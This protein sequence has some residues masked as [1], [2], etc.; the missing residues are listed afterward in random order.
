MNINYENIAQQ[1]FDNLYHDISN[2]SNINDISFNYQN[3]RRQ[4]VDISSIIPTRPTARLITSRLIPSRLIP[5]R[6]ISSRL[7]PYSLI[8]IDIYYTNR[9]TDA[10]YDSIFVTTELS[11]NII[12]NDLSNDNYSNRTSLRELVRNL[13]SE[14]DNSFL[15]NFINSTFE[16]DKQKFKK[17][18]SNDELEKL[19]PQKFNKKNE[20]NT[21]IQCPIYCYDFEENE[22]IIKLPC[23]HNYNCEGITKWLTEESNT[24]PV[25]RYEFDYKE[26]NI[27]NKRRTINNDDI[28]SNSEYNDVDYNYEYTSDNSEENNENNENNED[29]ISDYLIS[30]EEELL[31]EILL[32]SYSNNTTN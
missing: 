4:I 24:C 23:N 32:Y 16:N 9:R 14:E 2:I 30:E 28:E 5:S 29:N 21:N 31:Q 6:L 20:S 11:N 12:N 10:S 26:I 15:E 22:K 7:I 1:L 18:I 13:Y 25:C 8:P 3:I 17:V 19:K 27:D